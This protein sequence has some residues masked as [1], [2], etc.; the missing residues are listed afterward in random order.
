MLPLVPLIGIFTKLDGRDRIE[1]EK[2][3]SP[4]IPTATEI[5]SSRAQV[6]QRTT[7]FVGELQKDIRRSR[8]PPDAFISVR[9]AYV[10]SQGTF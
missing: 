6:E 2:L 10:L 9:S 4:R 5:I 8:H 3:F 7:K 1:R